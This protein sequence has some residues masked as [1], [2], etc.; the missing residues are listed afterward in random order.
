MASLSRPAAVSSRRVGDETFTTG[1]ALG[2]A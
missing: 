2:I 1:P